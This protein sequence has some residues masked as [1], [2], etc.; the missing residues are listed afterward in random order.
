MFNLAIKFLV[1][2]HIH[3][4]N[5]QN[6]SNLDYIHCNTLSKIAEKIIIILILQYLQTYSK[7]KNFF[8]T[9]QGSKLEAAS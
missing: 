8:Y 4:K 9:N 1:C 7:N 3:H 6:S 5:M 2:L